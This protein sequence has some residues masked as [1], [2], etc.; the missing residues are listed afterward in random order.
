MYFINDK[1]R[2][3][4]TLPDSEGNALL[5]CEVHVD[6]VVLGEISGS[7]QVHKERHSD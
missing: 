1:T 6:G 5:T 2:T 3:A 7:A 4:C